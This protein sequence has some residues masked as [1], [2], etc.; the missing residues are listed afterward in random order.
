MRLSALFLTLAAAT[1]VS[2]RSAGDFIKVGGSQVSI[3]EDLSVP[4]KNPLSFC[5]APTD[6]ILKID[7]VDLDP[8][9]PEA[10]KTLNIS[11]SGTLRSK[12]EEGSTIHLQVKYGLITLINQQTPLCDQ[13][14]NVDLE[15]PLEKGEMK[16]SKSVDLPREIPPGKYT[17]L[18]DVYTKEDKRIT[19]LTATITFG[20]H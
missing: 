9:P 5:S 1:A 19:C 16:L 14:K 2:A 11:A 13:V 12:V 15:C 6:D 3:N 7:H 18:A 20:R 10:G 4:G 8:N 17:V